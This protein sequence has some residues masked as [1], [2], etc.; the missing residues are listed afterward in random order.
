MGCD[1]AWEFGNLGAFLSAQT[2]WASSWLSR[3]PCAPDL[4]LCILIL[5]QNRNMLPCTSAGN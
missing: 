5:L 2:P 3:F 4:Y 1:T